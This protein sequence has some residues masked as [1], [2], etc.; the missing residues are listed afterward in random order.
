M[1][2]VPREHSDEGVLFL[3]RD[4]FKHVLAKTSHILSCAL[5]F[6][7]KHRQCSH[8]GKTSPSHNPFLSGSMCFRV[9]LKTRPLLNHSLLLT[10][11]FDD[12]CRA[13]LCIQICYWQS[14]IFLLSIIPLP[15]CEGQGLKSR[16]GPLNGNVAP[17][18]QPITRPASERCWCKVR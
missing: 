17:V 6:C 13:S 11:M 1:F 2:K 15:A 12:S 9:Y 16:S 5:K 7:D 14:F 4:A 3:T 8:T 10:E 18:V